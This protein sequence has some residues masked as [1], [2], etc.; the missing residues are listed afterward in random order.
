MKHLRPQD[1]DTLYGESKADMIAEALRMGTGMQCKGVTETSLSTG[2][3]PKAGNS[4]NGLLKTCTPGAEQ[5][6]SGGSKKTKEVVLG[7][8][9]RW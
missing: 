6:S 9:P 2:D 8:E 1:N 3:S 7:L 5:N 4:P